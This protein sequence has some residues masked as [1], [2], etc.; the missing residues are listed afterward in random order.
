M[1]ETTIIMTDTGPIGLV[2]TLIDRSNLPEL[3]ENELSWIGFLR[4]IS[5]HSDPPPSLAA[6]QSLR[7]ALTAY[8]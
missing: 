5:G 6:V 3:T 7:R 2:Q 1:S 4:A 8:R